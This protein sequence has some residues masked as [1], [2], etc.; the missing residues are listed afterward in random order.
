M[1][2][3]F[4]IFFVSSSTLRFV[5]I[6]LFNRKMTIRS[7][8]I[9]LIGLMLFCISCRTPPKA[10]LK[11]FLPAGTLVYAETT[12]LAKISGVFTGNKDWKALSGDGETYL[13]FLRD[14]QAALGLVG[15]E[16]AGEGTVL[17]VKPKLVLLIDTASS[18]PQ[19]AAVAERVLQELSQRFLK[20]N[21]EIEKQVINDT[22][23]LI[24][25]GGGK[26][27]FSAVIGSVILIG[28]NE[29]AVKQ[30]LEIKKSNG[31]SLSASKELMQAGERFGAPDQI[32][33]GYVSTA[34]IAELANYLTVSYALKSSENVLVREMISGLMPQMLQKTVSSV[35]WSARATGSGVEDTYFIETEKEFAR[36]VS[37]TIK[38]APAATAIGATDAKFIPKDIYSVSVYRLE[39]PQI[40]WRGMVLSL[41][42]RLDQKALPLF[43]QFSRQLL[44]P[45]GIDDP[46]LFLSAVESQIVT[47][48]FDEEGN[49]AVVIAAVKD[50][51]KLKR[52]ISETFDTG[53]APVTI[54]G[55]EG[56]A[57]RD[58]E[59]Y[60]LISDGRLIIGNEQSILKCLTANTET[61]DLPQSFLGRGAIVVT[62]QKDDTAVRILAD[63]ASRNNKTV[64][65]DS[66]AVTE[67]KI[68]T[69]GIKRRTL[70]AFGLPGEMLKQT[71]E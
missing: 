27:I 19:A 13:S 65:V 38:A 11:S 4:T 35:T 54:G 71:L 61:L 30:C 70:S 40:A 43:E 22:Q 8:H 28:N 2:I 64:E 55:A 60:A 48:R 31:E 39:E 17:Q 3:I 67:T 41:A 62:R 24:I 36:N 6:L 26:K 12:D 20:E 50:K 42:T 18:E 51:E 16:S 46:E 52:A 68:E 49:E 57:S 58:G 23:W 34:G 59:F 37:Q 66:Y 1:C 9:L 14:K 69:R 15:F 44:K 56:W 29:E 10:D 21:G 5:L 63:L 32:A 33:F 25:T 47:A 7:L 45:Y 53:K